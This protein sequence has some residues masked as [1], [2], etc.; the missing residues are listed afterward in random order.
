MAAAVHF[1]REL[2]V[3]TDRELYVITIRVNLKF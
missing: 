1:D 2:Y 3:I